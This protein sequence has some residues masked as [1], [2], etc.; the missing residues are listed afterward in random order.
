MSRNEVDPPPG[1]T[2]AGGSS[3]RRHAPLAR[4]WVLPLLAGLI[5]GFASWL[6]GEALHRRFEHPDFALSGPPSSAEVMSSLFRAERAAQRLDAI[7]SFGSLGA[8]LGMAHGL[9]GGSVRGSVRAALIAGIVGSI[10]GGLVGA[11]VTQVILPIYHRILDPDTNELMVGIVIHVVISSAIGA[12]G[13]AAFGFGLG[14]RSRGCRAVVGALL[15]AVAGSLVYEIVGALAFP[16]D[17]TSKPIAATWGARLFARLAVTTFA[18]A[19]LAMCAL[20]HAEA[21]ILSPVT[22]EHST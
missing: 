14:D 19:G 16:L 12:V 18:S 2:H 11:A 7:L 4:V 10:L 15:G 8:V 6:I 21:A 13:G 5:A 22:E 17:G 3:T 9:A 1:A 20:D